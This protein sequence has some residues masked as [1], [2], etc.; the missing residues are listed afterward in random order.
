M[1]RQLGKQ[2]PNV[3]FVTLATEKINSSKNAT[4]PKKSELPNHHES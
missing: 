3:E 4:L 2:I 1:A